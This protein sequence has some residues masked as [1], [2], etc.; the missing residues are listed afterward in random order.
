MPLE[1]G[2]Y[3]PELAA[4]RT[5]RRRYGVLGGTF[6]PPHYGHLVIAQEVLWALRLDLMVFVPAGSPPH[7]QGWIISPPEQR[8]EM[9]E[10]A[11]MANP[12]FALSRVDLDRP[13]PSYT[14][15]TLRLL[16]QEWGPETAIYWTM[17]WD[18]LDE[19]LTWH[20]P[21]GI[22]AT[23]DYVVA[24]HRPGYAHDGAAIARLEA[25][26]PGASQ[27]V[28]PLAVPQYAI[29]STS[30][31]QRVAQNMPIRYQVP[32][33]V[34]AYIREHG[35]YRNSD[36]QSAMGAQQPAA[37]LFHRQPMEGDSAGCSVGR[38]AR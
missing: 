36:Q 1:C 30:L 26:I 27:K 28:I 9:V 8:R 4:D 10:L 20:D 33:A 35:L 14:V 32:E 38:E 11:I 5:I 16:R 23:A 13:G 18:M 21:A 17:G 19:I 7:K 15:D 25:A 34:E 6:D 12:G 37:P 31:R 3:Q 22:F 24:M 2:Y 29:T